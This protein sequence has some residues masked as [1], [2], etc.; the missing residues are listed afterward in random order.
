[1]TRPLVSIVTPSYNQA[2]FLE[3]TIRSVL[4]QDYEP[5]EYI[6]VDGGSTDAS[7][8]II[9]R[10]ED[11]LSWWTSEPDG[12]QPQGLNKGFARSKGELMSYLNSDD[13]LLP[14]AVSRLVAE[15]ERDPQAL[16]AYGDAV[17]VDEHGLETHYGKS[18]VWDIGSMARVATG[19]VMPSASLW[20]RRAWELAGPFEESY[21]VWFDVLF[22]LNLARLGT[23]TY[24]EE[25]F[26][27]YRIHPESKTANATGIPHTEELIRVA[28]E[29]FLRPDLPEE[30]R[31]HARTARAGYFRR[32]AWGYYSS[33]DIAAARRALLRS[34]PLRPR[35]SRKTV[36]LL[37]RTLTPEPVIRLRNRLA[38]REQ[39]NAR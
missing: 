10:Y 19:T 8:E 18:K 11:R 29:F 13:T 23:A 30:L 34:V 21:Q 20:R 2:A 4:E 7:V 27:T 15:L 38:G 14:G 36:R 12:G 6:V 24:V 3:E 39:P 9:R 33:G 31:P 1:M 35:M 26:A 5:I 22:F 28:D 17:Y 32:A 25:P 37:A 16:V